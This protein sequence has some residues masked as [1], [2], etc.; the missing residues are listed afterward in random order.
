M[1]ISLTD[2]IFS[3]VT[4]FPASLC[5]CGTDYHRGALRVSLDL[6]ASSKYANTVLTVR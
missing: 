5:M 2:T 4:S 6:E 3:H 1:K